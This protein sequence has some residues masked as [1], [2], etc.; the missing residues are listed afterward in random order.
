MSVPAVER[1]R[2]AVGHSARSLVILLGIVVSFA[3][4][5]TSCS[6][7][8]SPASS[9]TTA[10][11]A[12][13]NLTVSIT[14]ETQDRTGS[15]PLPITITFS[16]GVS[17]FTAAM[18]TV[19]NGTAGS[20][21]GGPSIYTCDITPT[22][23]GPI[24]VDIPAGVVQ[25]AATND[26]DA[27]PQFTRTFITELGFDAANY[28]AA[29]TLSGFT[30][31]PNSNRVLVAAVYARKTNNPSISGVTYGGASMTLVPGSEITG[32]VTSP[33]HGILA[34][35]YYLKDPAAGT[36]DVVATAPGA[37][38]V[39]IGVISLYD[40]YVHGGNDPIGAVSS[41]S[42]GAVTTVTTNITTTSDYSWLVDAVAGDASSTGFTA[43]VGQMARWSQSAASGSSAGSTKP[44]ASSG[45]TTMKWSLGTAQ[46]ALVHCVA[47][48]KIAQ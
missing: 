29:A 7:P 35:L 9:E 22:A 13:S 41:Q 20:V 15:N 27:A 43:D 48:I 11:T 30:V 45:A 36:A 5:V 33:K 47:E 16:E 32:S 31:A 12:A 28:A 8:A 21:S 17:G 6:A 38:V 10:T 4:L 42:A 46:G 26:N 18:L 37:Q 25:D 3:G 1:F 14:S 23:A 39:Q 24:T 34:A 2:K 40:A 19:G 44:A